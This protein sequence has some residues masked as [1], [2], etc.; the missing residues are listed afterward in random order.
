MNTILDSFIICA[1]Q[2]ENRYARSTVYVKV[3]EIKNSKYVLSLVFKPEHATKFNEDTILKLINDLR[4]KNKDLC[5]FEKEQN[6]LYKINGTSLSR[7][8]LDDLHEMCE[9]LNSFR[10]RT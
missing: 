8:L 6:N 3:D 5:Y 1:E 7:A 9:F 4:T 2:G 10:S